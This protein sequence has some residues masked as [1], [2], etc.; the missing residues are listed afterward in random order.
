[1]PFPALWAPG[2]PRG[3][4]DA[5]PQALHALGLRQRLYRRPSSS[6]RFVENFAIPTIEQNAGNGRR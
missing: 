6:F 1:M 3:G 5:Q 4:H 2:F